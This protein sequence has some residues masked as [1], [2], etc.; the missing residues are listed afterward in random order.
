MDV[1]DDINVCQNAFMS[2]YQESVKRAFELS[3]AKYELVLLIFLKN[4]AEFER[5]S[6]RMCGS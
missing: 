6:R 1:D 4:M 3:K 5:K 2:L